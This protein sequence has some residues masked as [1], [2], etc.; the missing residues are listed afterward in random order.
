ME[1]WIQ[2]VVEVLPDGTPYLLILFLIAFSE[3]L[4]MIGLLMP[5]STLVV[6]A[7]FLCVPQKRGRLFYLYCVSQKKRITAR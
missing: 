3:S 6:L 2:Q 7:G 1:V 5:G 4:P